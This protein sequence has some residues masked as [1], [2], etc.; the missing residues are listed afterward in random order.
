ML[1]DPDAL[2]SGQV[3]S[4]FNNP[5][6]WVGRIREPEVWDTLVRLRRLAL[7]R[8][9]DGVAN[10]LTNTLAEIDMMRAAL[11]IERQMNDA[12]EDW[13]PYLRRR[14]L[15]MERDATVR[16]AQD[17]GFEGVLRRLEHATTLNRFKIWVEGPT[18]CPPVEDLAHK[19]AGAENLNIVAQPLGGWATIL[20]PQWHPGPLGDG[21]HD[22][23]ILLD[24]DRAYNYRRPGLVLHPDARGVLARLRRAGVEVKVLDRYGLENYFPPHAFET[25]MGHDLVAHFPLDPRRSV[26]DQIPRYSK[27]MN[28][29][30]ARLTTLADLADTDLRDFLERAARLAGD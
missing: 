18:D 21:C 15:E 26:S 22:F 19:V 16:A 7:H 29:D 23:V 30:L 17:V 8:G 28:A 9:L 12:P 14:A 13:R 1:D 5:L 6:N 24:G 3:D 11:I 4:H 25:V 2:A 27:N 10:L 20:N